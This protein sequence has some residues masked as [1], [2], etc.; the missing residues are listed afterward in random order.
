MGYS[1]DA[2]RIF[3]G[4][5]QSLFA[6]NK[7]ITWKLDPKTTGIIIGDKHFIDNPL[8]EYKPAIIVSRGSLRW[9]Q[10]TIDQRMDYN[11]V[12]LDKKY[13][14]IIYGSLTYNILARSEFAAERL[15]DYFFEQL[16]GHRDQFRKNGINNILN[17]QM[18]DCVILK[19]STDVE[20]TNVPIIISYAMQRSIDLSHDDFQDISVTSQLLEA[21]YADSAELGM[22]GTGDFG[23][24][25]FIQGVDY[26]VSGANLVFLNIPSGVELTITYIGGTTYTT[27]Q[28]TVSVPINSGLEV[29]SLQ[30]ELNQIYPTY[31]GVLLGDQI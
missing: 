2:K 3:L 23:K 6:Q 14:D 7:A 25:E 26:L 4:F 5:A 24:G 16:T 27:Y 15:A 9:G 13:T 31:S 12:N 17:I 19:S 18:G 8:I 21:A 22:A 28:D 11:L 30:E 10:H 29:Y 1:I 20:Y